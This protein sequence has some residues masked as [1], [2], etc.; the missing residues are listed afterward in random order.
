MIYKPFFEENNTDLTNNNIDI[1]SLIEMAQNLPSKEVLEG[2]ATAA[3]VLEGKT[4]Y[5]DD[6]KVKI[7][8][9]IPSKSAATFTPSTSDQ[10]ITVGQYL[11][12]DQTIKGDE[13]LKAENIKKGVSIFDVAGS[14]EEGGKWNIFTQTAE[15][16]ATDGLWIKS[17][18][19]SK[20]EI[21]E[22]ICVDGNVYL[23]PHSLYQLYGATSESV[24]GKI[25]IL[26]GNV[27]N[28]DE[29]QIMSPSAD[30]RMFD[31]VEKTIITLSSTLPSPSCLGDSTCIDNIIYVVGGLYKK[32][33]GTSNKVQAFDPKTNIASE[34]GTLNYVTCVQAVASFNNKIY[35][36]GG[37]TGTGTDEYDSSNIIGVYDISTKQSATVSS[38]LTKSTRFLSAA[39][40]GEKIYIIGFYESNI[41]NIFDPKTNIVTT[42]PTFPKYTEKMEC[43]AI[44]SIIY[45]ISTDGLSLIKYDTTTNIVSIVKNISVASTAGWDKFSSAVVDGT[46]YAIDKHR[47]LEY[48][49][50]TNNYDTG[51]AVVD[52]EVG[53]TGKT[54]LYKDDKIEL[55]YKIKDVLYQYEDGLR[56]IDAAVNINGAGWTTV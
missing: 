34:H 30:I 40:V 14:M 25:Y 42:G 38:V 15:P 9:T 13:N 3:D 29:Y 31:P 44:G 32:Y 56:H 47:V 8:G 46:F 23:H 17:D 2:D 50:Y 45:T 26:G 22:P 48:P 36:F 11:S 12:G 4:F 51:T 1:Q 43:S 39:T 10:I 54:S 55:Q 21:G 53:Y 41:T 5:S 52:L 20:V 35:H 27:E 28:P 7:T 49:V 18:D 6:A 33:A 16:D 37:G 24:N 19:V